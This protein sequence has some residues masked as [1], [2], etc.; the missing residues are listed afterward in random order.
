MPLKKPIFIVG[1]PRSGT[2]LLQCMLSANSTLFS[3]PETHFFSEV[4][5]RIAKSSDA[6]LTKEEIEKALKI[7]NQKMELD[8]RISNS[9]KKFCTKE[10]INGKKLFEFI[11]ESY[12]PVEDRLKRL[13]LVEK[14]P[15]HALFIHEIKRIYPE[16]LFIHIIRNPI[17]V[18]SSYIVML[19]PKSSSILKCISYWNNLIRKVQEICRLYPDS[20]LNI[21]YEDLVSDPVLNL[22][23][24]CRFLDIEFERE[25]VTDFSSQAEKNILVKKEIWK[26][27]VSS[28]KIF[29][30]R[31]KWQERIS[32][33]QAWLIEILTNNFMAEYGYTRCIRPKFRA[34]CEIIIGELKIA[35]EEGDGRKKYI[36]QIFESL[37]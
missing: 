6:D 5:N 16:S 27:E 10:K 21:R 14:T 29:Q 3:L 11:I 33:A 2:T 19:M 26:N 7:L 15:N 20:V 36:K 34:K 13:R 25:M 23:K 37:I 12:R 9:L 31:D 32:E 22:R 24:V 28:G 30:N 8:S 1:F 17:N 4:M 18:I 35:K